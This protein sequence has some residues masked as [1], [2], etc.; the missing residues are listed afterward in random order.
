VAESRPAPGTTKCSLGSGSGTSKLCPRA[1]PL[2]CPHRG[3]HRLSLGAVNGWFA[4]RSIWAATGPYA[5][6]SIALGF[7]ADRGEKALEVDLDVRGAR[8]AI[9]GRSRPPRDGS[10]PAGPPR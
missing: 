8:A 1:P 5:D 10:R 7:L 6:R 3:L 4:Q 9:D 2:R